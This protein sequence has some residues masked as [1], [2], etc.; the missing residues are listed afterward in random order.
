M[1]FTA[2]LY[3]MMDDLLDD[4]G[5]EITISDGAYS[6]DVS[7][8]VGRQNRQS[9]DGNGAFVNSETSTFLMSAADLVLNGITIEPRPG[10][11][12][13]R[14]TKVYQ[15]QPPTVGEQCFNWIG[16]N[17]DMLRIYAVQVG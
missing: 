9:E 16:P 11:R 14:R 6:V 17:R 5:E 12:I 2:D 8:M 3:S 10:L 13:E 4:R 15:V 1:T 7:A